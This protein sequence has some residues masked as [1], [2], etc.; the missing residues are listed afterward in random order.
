[1]LPAAPARRGV[2]FRMDASSILVLAGALAMDATAVAAVCGFAVPRVTLRFA[3]LVALL[4]GGFQAVMPVIGWGIGCG[5]GDSVRAWDHWIA[6]AV[7]GGLGAKMLFEALRGGAEQGE[8]RR[9]LGLRLLLGM[10]VAT[11]IDALAV[12]VTLP[13]L[14]APFFATVATIGVVTAAMSVAGLLLGRQFER[15]LGPR[16]DVVGGVVLIGLGVKIL[17]E[18]LIA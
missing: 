9:V 2:E 13:L 1:M 8:R 10:A 18:H 7:L 14:G 12:G 15:A 11:S 5:L 16:L 4:F 3:L 17:V 6:F